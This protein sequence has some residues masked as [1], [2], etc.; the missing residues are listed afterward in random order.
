M[1]RLAYTSVGW[2]FLET[3]AKSFNFTLP[4]KKNSNNALIRRSAIAMKMNSAFTEPFV[5]NLLWY[6]QF[7]LRQTT[8][9][10]TGQ[11]TAGFDLVDVSRLYVAT[12][13]E[14]NF[15]LDM[16]SLSSDKFQ[17]HFELVFDLTSMQ[18]ATKNFPFLELCGKSL[19]LEINVSLP[20]EDV[21]ELTKLGD[22]ISLV[23]VDKI[24]V[25]EAFY[26]KDN[27]ALQQIIIRIP[28]LMYR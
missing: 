9:F 13:K 15:Q 17:D 26:E 1:V 27:N 21:I 4:Q 20:L 10:K 11:P 22:W 25:V 18:H 5:E 19:R 24:G 7:Q 23:A 6:Q 14:M 28:L 8:M 16:P 3:P 12:L 2:N